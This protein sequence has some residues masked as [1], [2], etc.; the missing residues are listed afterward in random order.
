[1]LNMKI[2]IIIMA[3][4]GVSSASIGSLITYYTVVNSIEIKE[5]VPPQV[6]NKKVNIKQ[7]DGKRYW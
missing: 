4:V 1:M 2:A 3:V 5:C 6:E 7:G